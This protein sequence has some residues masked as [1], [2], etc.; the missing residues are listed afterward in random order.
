[1]KKSLTILCLTWLVGNVCAQ[2]ETA[3][4]ITNYVTYTLEDVEDSI[5][6]D[7]GNG[8]VNYHRT[9]W[10]FFQV[11]EA[12]DYELLIN[13]QGA[14]LNTTNGVK[15]K[16]FGPF[17]IA[18]TADW[19]GTY[20]SNVSTNA[21]LNSNFFTIGNINSQLNESQ[22]YLMFFAKNSSYNGQ[23]FSVDLNEDV[24]VGAYCNSCMP[25]ESPEMCVVTSTSEN[26][27]KIIWEK[28]DP[29][30][31]VLRYNVWRDE[32]GGPVLAGYATSA[33]SSFVIDTTCFASEQAYSYTL[34]TIDTCYVSDWAVKTHQTVHLIASPGFNGENNLIWN[35]YQ[36]GTAYFPMINEPFYIYRGSDPTE[37]VLIDSVV[38]SDFLSTFTYTDL[39]APEGDIYYQVAFMYDWTC[40]V[41]R[42]LE[43]SMVRSNITGLSGW[44]AE[45]IFESEMNMEVYPNPATGQI[46]A[47]LGS[48]ASG[49]A[50]VTLLDATG[51][52]V[53]SKQINC[54]GRLIIDRESSS[55]GI[56]ILE[57]KVNNQ[58]WRGR[59]M[60]E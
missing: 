25:F 12:P 27:N 3:T 42:D 49:L 2:C 47:E 48:H 21:S 26:R 58:T 56:Y 20:L 16:V 5:Q 46:V 53:I 54:S 7:F 33:D 28:E 34:E 11:C 24:T 55:A 13:C 52:T 14:A 18:D 57:V 6:L 60:F 4:L 31:Y 36:T 10:F 44:L 15:L 1:M 22:F 32:F 41:I 43:Q 19:C 45:S 8:M 29:D 30:D 51:R 38:T 35:A 39:N 40:V 50:S 59:V 23:Q 37:L 17:T 9:N